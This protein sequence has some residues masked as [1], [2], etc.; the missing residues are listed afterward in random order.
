MLGCNGAWQYEELLSQLTRTCRDLGRH[1]EVLSSYIPKGHT[2]H[3]LLGSETAL[4]VC[5]LRRLLE[6]LCNEKTTL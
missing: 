3:I 4:L 5:L 6:L 2:F 1:W